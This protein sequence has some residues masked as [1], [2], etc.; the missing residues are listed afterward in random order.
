MPIQE[1]AIHVVASTVVR[2]VL[3]HLGRTEDVT[4]SP[5]DK[6]LAVAGF[7]ENVILI[8]D[9]EIDSTPAGPSIS[10]TDRVLLR[11]ESLRAPHGVSFLDEQ[12][13]IVANRDGR[14]TV[15][16]VPAPG[17]DEVLVTPLGVVGGILFRRVKTPGSVEVRQA[18]P[19]VYDV[20]VC[21][22]YGHQVT[23]H[24]VDL[25]SGLSVKNR[26]ALLRQRLDVPDGICL[27]RDGE[28]LAVSNHMSG[29]VFVYAYGPRLGKGSC[30]DGILV[31]IDCPHGVRFTADGRYVLVAAAAAPLVHVFAAEDGD[32]R[33]RREPCR[34][35]RVLDEATFRRGRSNPEEGGPK[36]LAVDGRTR[37]LA[38]TCEEQPL[39]FFDLRE[40]LHRM[41]G[42]EA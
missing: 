2:D 11:S 32:W 22:N 5:S 8:L 24:S 29:E 25:R 20:L 34:S 38:V 36:G 18:Q 40:I 17:A 4:F 19:G 3:A 9:V 39:A 31:G 37:V 12:T 1:P 23:A 13:I 30:P 15:F 10:L 6:R 41:G 33:G 42:A 26:G 7:A 16:E 35:A 28:W 14:V 21:N 27:S